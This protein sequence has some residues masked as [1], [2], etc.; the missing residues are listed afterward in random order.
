MM[1]ISPYLILGLHP[2]MTTAFSE[3]HSPCPHMTF[4]PF[5]VSKIILI[6]VVVVVTYFLLFWIQGSYSTYLAF[7]TIVVSYWTFFF[8]FACHDENV[9]ELMEDKERRK[10]NLPHRKSKIRKSKP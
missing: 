10:I 7:A 5:S 6:T 9:L 2:S 3:G 8:F 4:L 1:E